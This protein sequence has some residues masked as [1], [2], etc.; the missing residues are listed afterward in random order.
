VFMVNHESP[1]YTLTLTTPP[2]DGGL[3]VTLSHPV[4]AFNPATITF[5]A[6]QLS[7]T[8]S[9]TPTDLPLTDNVIPQLN[10]AITGPDAALYEYSDVFDNLQNL[11]ILPELGFSSVPALYADDAVAGL[12]V[13]LVNASQ[14][15]AFQAQNSFA[16]YVE[17]EDNFNLDVY[18]Q[19]SVLQFSTQSL[20]ANALS[21]QVS[22]THVR[23]STFCIG[24]SVNSY[25][26]FWSLKFEGRESPHDISAFVPLDAQRVIVT[27]HQIEP[28]F[29][30]QLD[31]SWQDAS[32][33]ISRGPWAPMTLI[34][35]QAYEDGQKTA[36]YGGQRT[37]GG[38]VVFDPAVIT[39]APGQ[40]VSQ[41]RV[42]AI[43]GNDQR[44]VYYR[45]E[46]EIQGHEDDLCN[47]LEW[48]FPRQD[49][50][51]LGH[52]AT[53]HVAPAAHLA[54]SALLVALLALFL[55]FA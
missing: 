35:H 10:V 7:A 9:F 40:Q 12:T 4:L 43:P 30:D 6:G 50:F 33:N 49:G 42:Q 5:A 53:W 45:V 22:I 23:P 20:A 46:W 3:S 25:S 52:F 18:L 32:F 13:W 31:F 15:F 36:P 54:V 28:D 38:R 26:L 17:V 19:P 39:F 48:A 21:Q 44:E 1:L 41:F 47:Y 2:G 8:F 16:V 14:P 11:E 27:R 51:G 29:P 37:A 55:V 24:E 34:P